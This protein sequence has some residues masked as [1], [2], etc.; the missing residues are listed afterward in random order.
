MAAGD[1]VRRRSVTG[2]GARL[3]HERHPGMNRN[4]VMTDGFSNADSERL[5]R[6]RWPEEPDLAAQCFEDAKQCGGC[7]FFAKFNMDWGL[8]CHRGSRHHLETVFE[9][10]TCR[11][12]VGEGWCH[13]SFSTSPVYHCDAAQEE[14]G[15]RR[16]RRRKAPWWRFWVD[17]RP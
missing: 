10:F 15:E 12:I 17:P 1:A 6:E 8:C 4:K 9:H 11:S 2:D 7:S 14:H 13:H 5:F 16:R 3:D